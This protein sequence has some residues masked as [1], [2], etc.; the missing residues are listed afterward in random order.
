MWNIGGPI[1]EERAGALATMRANIDARIWVLEETSPSATASIRYIITSSDANFRQYMRKAWTA[2]QRPFIYHLAGI[3]IEDPTITLAASP[4]Y[5]ARAVRVTVNLPM[6]DGPVHLISFHAPSRF[7]SRRRYFLDHFS[8]IMQGNGADDHIIIAGDWND[9]ANPAMDRLSPRSWA[10]SV[11]PTAIAP[12]LRQWSLVDVFRRMQPT[13]RAY[14]RVAAPTNST[15]GNATRIDA[16]FATFLLQQTVLAVE[17]HPSLGSDHHILVLLFKD[18]VSLRAPRGAGWWY[19]HSALM[20][21]P[22]YR[23][24]VGNY[25]FFIPGEPQDDIDAWYAALDKFRSWAINSSVRPGRQNVLAMGDSEE[26][27]RQLNSIALLDSE[28]CHR[29]LELKQKLDLSCG[30]RSAVSWPPLGLWLCVLLARFYQQLLW[31]ALPTD[32]ALL[33]GR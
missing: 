20:S 21:H 25:Q 29:F 33:G 27:Q 24:D 16:A 2:D 11:W 26:M 32:A 10:Q 28:D 13:Q 12:Q 1:S 14:S 9:L 4:L 30:G 17:Y 15:P 3:I 22:A 18:D 6:V 23:I 8:E 7:Q 19:F 31:P 5:T